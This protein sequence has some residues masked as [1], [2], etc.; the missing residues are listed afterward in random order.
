MTKEE[1]RKAIEELDEAKKEYKDH[2]LKMFQDM[3][4]KGLDKDGAV[5]N[6]VMIENYGPEMARTGRNLIDKFIKIQFILHQ[7]AHKE[8]MSFFE[9]DDSLVINL[10]LLITNEFIQNDNVRDFFDI[11]AEA[12]SHWC[13]S[14]IKNIVGEITGKRVKVIH[15][16]T[17]EKRDDT[18]D[19]QENKTVH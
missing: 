14:E 15:V 6:A 12:V 11:F 8:I 1:V 9:E 3:K 4:R 18:Q 5:S 16:G 7:H 17:E 19:K 10:L 13:N 2:K